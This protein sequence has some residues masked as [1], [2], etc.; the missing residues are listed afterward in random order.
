MTDLSQEQLEQ[1]FYLFLGLVFVTAAVLVVYVALASRRAKADR[2]RGRAD[3][4]LAIRPEYLVVGQ[5]LSLVR[6]APGAA[7][8]VEVDGVKY[9]SLAEIKD[10]QLRRQIMAGAM[11]LIQF[12]GV[13][14]QKDLSPAPIS[15]TETWRE[16]LRQG[17]QT[18]LESARRA[19]GG[20]SDAPAPERHSVARPGEAEEQFLDLLA[21]MGQSQV[22]P[23]KPTVIGAV[24]QRLAPKPQ[25][26]DRP[27]SFI[28]EIEE[29]IQRRIP[30]MPALVGRGLHVQ[31][32]PGGE[33]LFVFEGKTYEN[34]ENLPNLTARELVQDAIREW[35]ETTG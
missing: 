17:S 1:L 14:A 18:E 29:I 10:P 21:D 12:T 16:D 24:Q 35:D 5:V 4:E 3:D 7:L 34:L 19:T 2:S 30:L 23:E 9:S 11:E 33:V 20:A 25:E 13:L 27:R 32:G 31:S 8:Q 26:P 15:R 22:Q 28:D 6:D